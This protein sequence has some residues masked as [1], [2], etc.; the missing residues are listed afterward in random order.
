M[1]KKKASKKSTKIRVETQE[2]LDVID[3]LKLDIKDNPR[4]MATPDQAEEVAVY[5]AAAQKIATMKKD[6]KEAPAVEEEPPAEAE[7]PAEEK[8]KPAA[9]KEPVIPTER[10]G[11]RVYNPETGGWVY[12]RKKSLKAR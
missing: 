6:K 12:P 7:K 9:K 8:K 4:A 1:A 2:V 11:G 3:E 5:I 10:F